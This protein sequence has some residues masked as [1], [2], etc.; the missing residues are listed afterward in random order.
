MSKR[1]TVAA[2]TDIREAIDRIQRYTSGLKVDEFLDNTEKQDAVVRNFEI[3]GE[4]VRHIPPEFRKRH[5]Q[6]E[7][8]EM[9]GFRD[10]LIHG[11]FGLNLRILWSVVEDKL[12][13]L[14]QQVDA[15]LELHRR[16]GAEAGGVDDKTPS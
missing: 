4:A 6:V 13:A 12:P 8:T 16:P 10:K 5:A 15:L 2:L 3:M 14:R 1:T 7:W 9:A 11:Y